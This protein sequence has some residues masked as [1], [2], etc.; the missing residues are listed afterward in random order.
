MEF[1]GLLFFAFV[2]FLIIRAK[3]RPSEKEVAKYTPNMATTSTESSPRMR[4][5]MVIKELKLWLVD[6]RPTDVVVFDTETNGLDPDRFSVLSVGA[7]RFTWNPI[8]MLIEKDRFDRYYFPVEPY[9]PQTIG[10]NGLTRE[11][12]EELRKGATYPEHFLDDD[13]FQKFCEGVHLFAGHNIS[14]DA[15]FVPFVRRWRNF[16]TMKS[17]SDVVCAEW[18]NSYNEWKWPSLEQ[19]ARFYSIPFSIENAH[20]AMYDAQITSSILIKM[21]KRAEIRISETEEV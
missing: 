17:N 1:F 12:I 21:L 3:S 20:G 11:K 4:R 6:I 15:G 2:A 8:A 19:T 9:N 14:F 18:N 7:I 10:V 5:D 13:G 16:D